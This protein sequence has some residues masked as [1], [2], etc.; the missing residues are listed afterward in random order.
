MQFLPTGAISTQLYKRE[1]AMSCGC[2]KERMSSSPSMSQTDEI[3]RQLQD[4]GRDGKL[5][6]IVVF[7]SRD[8]RLDRGWRKGV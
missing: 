7:Q 6:R 1:N 5:L 2:D 4:E 8:T 3:Y